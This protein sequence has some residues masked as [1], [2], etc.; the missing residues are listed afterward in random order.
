MDILEMEM[1]VLPALAIPHLATDCKHAPESPV[2]TGDIHTLRQDSVVLTAVILVMVFTVL[3]FSV[4]LVPSTE[5][6]RDNAV[7]G[8]IHCLTATL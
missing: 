2:T 4:L 7:E 5:F 6:Q 8:V 3:K 1:V